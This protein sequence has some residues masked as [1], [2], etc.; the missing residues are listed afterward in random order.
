MKK[1]A[2]VIEQ[3]IKLGY[4]I[5]PKLRK[6]YESYRQS[7]G[8][9]IAPPDTFSELI[10]KNEALRKFIPHESMREIAARKRTTQEMQS[11]IPQVSPFTIPTEAHIE[12][13]TL[14]E[15]TYQHVFTL[16]DRILT[17]T[18]A[19]SPSGLAPESPAVSEAAQQTSITVG[20]TRYHF[21]GSSIFSR[22]PKIITDLVG[23]HLE[24]TQKNTSV[25]NV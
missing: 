23:P 11:P 19:P 5:D 20:S 25:R 8:E 18:T 17:V 13:D 7:G 21:P 6:N 14:P 22:F 12:V 10:E 3:Q 9:I 16:G 1:W 4:P 24:E 2:I 15:P